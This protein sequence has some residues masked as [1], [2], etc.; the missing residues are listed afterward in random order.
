MPLYEHKILGIENIKHI[1]TK[2]FF[3]I[4]EYFCS[5]NHNISSA[6]LTQ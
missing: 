2:V 1:S 4:N 3:T 5:I 6:L